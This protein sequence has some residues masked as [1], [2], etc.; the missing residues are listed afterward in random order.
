VLL[1]HREVVCHD[2]ESERAS[3]RETHTRAFEHR[4]KVPIDAVDHAG[5]TA[6]HWAVYENREP[7]VRLL[8]TLGAN[9]NKP[10]DSVHTKS[11]T[12]SL[13]IYQCHNA[14]RSID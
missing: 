3:E 4:S 14:G 8:L 9:V 10:D 12:L 13:E 11:P 7:I 1:A 2:I 6:L 5:H